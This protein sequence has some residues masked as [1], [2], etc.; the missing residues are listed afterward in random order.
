MSVVFPSSY[1]CT[2]DA[3]TIYRLRFRGRD[4]AGRGGGEAAA[5]LAF[6]FRRPNSSFVLFL[7]TLLRFTSAL[8]S[9]EKEHLWHSC[10]EYCGFNTDVFLFLLIRENLL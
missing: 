1:N 9:I 5:C 3:S 8:G 6:R 10:C 7:E 4:D 2:S